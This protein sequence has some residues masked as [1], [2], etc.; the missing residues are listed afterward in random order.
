MCLCN[1]PLKTFYILKR[2]AIEKITSII[3]LVTYM[4]K[5]AVIYG[6]SGGNTKAV[7]QQIVDKL[8]NQAD[9]F[10]VSEL[11]VSDLVKY[12]YLILGTSTTGIGDLQYDWEKILPSLQNVDLKDKKVAIFGLGDSASYSES[13]AQS[14]R[15]LYDGLNERTNIVGKVKDEGYTYDESNSVI[16]GEWVG[17]PLDEDN[18]YDMTDERLNNWLEKLK[19]EFV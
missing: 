2:L 19:K 7:A 17:L 15:R 8:D 10:D 5:I 18:E 9:I 12:P 6:S 3:N 16:D 4:N 11:S 14:M 13:F 1:T